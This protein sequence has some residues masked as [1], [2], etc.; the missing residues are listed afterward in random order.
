M[1]IKLSIITVL[2]VF[3]GLILAHSI[4]LPIYTKRHLQSKDDIESWVHQQGLNLRRKYNKPLYLNGNLDLPERSIIAL[5]NQNIDALVINLIIRFN[6]NLIDE[7]V[8][9]MLQ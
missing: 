4:N 1:M 3:I 6:I 5:T 8:T 7:S 2:S 9:I